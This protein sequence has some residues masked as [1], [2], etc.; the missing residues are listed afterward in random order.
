[1]NSY[2]AVLVGVVCAGIGGELFVR[3]SVGLAKWMRIPS[4]IVGAT[5]AAFATSSPELSVAITAG[6]AGEPQIALG[7]SLGSNVVNVALILG[8]ALIISGIQTPRSSLKRDFPIALLV[9][10]VTALMLFDGVLSRLD[11]VLLLLGFSA[12]LTA[13]I[14]EARRQRS[15]ATEVLAAAHRWSTI[16][17]CLLGLALLICAGKFIVTGAE[18]IAATYGVSQFV[19]GATVVAVGT[20]VPEL[21]TAVIAKIKGHDEIGLGTVLGSNIFNGLFVVGLVAVIHPIQVAWQSVFVA[22]TVG[23]VALICSFPPSSGFIERRRGVLLIAAY[24][25]YLVIVLQQPGH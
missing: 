13:T 16:G 9:P 18:D 15:S 11:G 6:L 25:A 4:G 17:S 20:S 7:D 10:I 12:W 8:A 22:L 21:A 14:I 1:M 24:C 5:V 3:G 2:L 19:I 23:V